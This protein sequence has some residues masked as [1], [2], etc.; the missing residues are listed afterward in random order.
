MSR[1]RV[2]SQVVSQ[3]VVELRMV[4]GWLADRKSSAGFLV[5]FETE[6]VPDVLE[7]YTFSGV[8]VL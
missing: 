7:S 4:S 6:P 3:T 8:A 5:D 2:A 1:A